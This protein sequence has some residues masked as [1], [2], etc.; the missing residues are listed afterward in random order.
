MRPFDYDKT[1]LPSPVKPVQALGFCEW[2][3]QVEEHLGFL[4]QSNQAAR[5]YNAGVA[6]MD[7]VVKLKG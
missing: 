1:D 5:L 7:A 3:M 2:L 6:V 4:V